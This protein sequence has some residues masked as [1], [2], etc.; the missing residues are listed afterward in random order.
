MF[1]GKAYL[2]RHSGATFQSNL[3]AQVNLE[4]EQS[5]FMRTVFPC[6]LQSLSYS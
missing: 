5:R 1:I 2:H 3:L 6:I 4:V